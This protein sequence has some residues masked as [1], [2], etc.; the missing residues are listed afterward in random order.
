MPPQPKVNTVVSSGLSDDP[1]DRIASASPIP[2]NEPQ[3]DLEREMTSTER[4]I[5]RQATAEDERNPILPRPREEM[6]DAELPPH[7]RRTQYDA[8]GQAYRD[9]AP[10]FS[11]QQMIAAG[12]SDREIM[13]LLRRSAGETGMVE[14]DLSTEED[15]LQKLRVQAQK[16]AVL[17]GG[18]ALRHQLSLME[19]YFAG[20]TERGGDKDVA[21][22][23]AFLRGK[24]KR[25]PY[26]SPVKRKV[27]INGYIFDIPPHKRVMLPEEVLTI[28]EQAAEAAEQFDVLSAIYTARQQR[29]IDGFV[30]GGADSF[31][32]SMA[33]NYQQRIPS[34]YRP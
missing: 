12:F 20:A 17:D 13:T 10:V 24:C 28:L 23:Q 18:T 32:A 14:F 2:G 22:G 7:L 19:S 5:H 4:T 11:Q 34:G 1:R 33:S 16:I 21:N 27:G 31:R 30:E 8:R 6:T 26:V 29:P 9:G 15:R 25:F 3:D